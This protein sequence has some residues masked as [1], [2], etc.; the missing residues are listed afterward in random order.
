MDIEIRT[1]EVESKREDKT[2]LIESEPEIKD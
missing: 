1:K 2:T